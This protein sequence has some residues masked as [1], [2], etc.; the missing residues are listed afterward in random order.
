MCTARHMHV[1]SFSFLLV[2][3]HRSQSFAFPLHIHTHTQ[4]PLLACMFSVFWKG[5]ESATEDNPK[6]KGCLCVILQRT[7]ASVANGA[8]MFMPVVFLTPFQASPSPGCATLTLPRFVLSHPHP[9]HSTL[10]TV[11]ESKIQ[12]VFQKKNV[13]PFT[14][15]CFF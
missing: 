8:W 3:C 7:Q 12:D 10:G 4:G 1:S 6:T 14:F 11:H 5:T 15:Y 9:S 2:F 13:F